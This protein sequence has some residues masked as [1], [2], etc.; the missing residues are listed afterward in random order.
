[1]AKR[2]VAISTADAST[3]DILNVIRM[4]ASQQYQDMIPEVNDE[5][6]VIGV[7]DILMGYPGLANEFISSLMNRIAFEVLKTL[8]F[9][10]PFSDLDK[11][12]VTN[13]QII[14]DIFIGMA[15]S[16]AY[17]AE[18]GASREFKRSVPDVKTAFY[19]MNWRVVIPT[20]IQQN[21]LVF[22]FQSLDG[23]KRFTERLISQIYQ[24]A[25]YQD[26]LLYKYLI[27]KNVAKGH[28]TP[29]AIGTGAIDDLKN[30]ISVI[31]ATSSKM[32]FP[33]T[34]YNRAGVKTNT[35]KERQ[36]IFVDADWEAQVD[37]NVLAAAFNMDKA[38]YL[39]ARYLVDNWDEFDNEAFE[40]IREETDMIEEVTQ[41]E[42]NIMKNVKAVLV[43]RDWF[44]VY[45]NLLQ[46]R[47][48]PVNSGLY[49]NYFYHVWK[50]L[51]TS[52]FAN[53]IVMVTESADFN[54]PEDYIG[55][56]TAKS[57]SEDVTIL[58]IESERNEASILGSDMKF[59]QTEEAT[60]AGIA[61]HPYGA[62]II[63]ANA[64]AIAV[65][66]EYNGNIYKS[67]TNVDNTAAVGDRITFHKQ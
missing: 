49:Y 65:E 44:Q 62:V 17:S 35:P 54:L 36:I 20:T 21:D 29:L 5:R 60:K 23:V 15:N 43:D 8:E 26:F 47:E 31:R 30:A 57:V 4:N 45:T 32:T 58:T 55:A 34:K 59:I 61:I 25:E 40:D 66:F 64:K 27:I 16:Y 46:M 13:G 56:V 7:G 28:M 41:D 9:T 2:K 12:M 51:A 42:L 19:S 63:P 39:G 22:A 48:T 50:T 52:P 18:K 24:T 3:L 1:M 67:T 38:E 53:A 6:G 14:E 33:S 11:G 10:N 37:V